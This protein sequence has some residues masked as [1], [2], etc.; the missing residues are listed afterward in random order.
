MLNRNPAI[1]LYQPR[2]GW[3]SVLILLGGS[4][5]RVWRSVQAAAPEA[6]AKLLKLVKQWQAI[7][8]DAHPSTKD[9]EKEFFMVTWEVLVNFLLA[10]PILIP[11]VQILNSQEPKPLI[12]LWRQQKI[13]KNIIHLKETWI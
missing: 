2:P 11:L 8:R 4:E 1:E 7:E 5:Y 10:I 6:H 13:R 9:Q 12:F 3:D